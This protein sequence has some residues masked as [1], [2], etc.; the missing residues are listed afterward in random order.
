MKQL[1]A[2]LCFLL[3]S[4]TLSTPASAKEHPAPVDS[5][6]VTSPDNLIIPNQRIGAIRLGMGMDEVRRLLGKPSGGVLANAA[7]NQGAIWSYGDLNLQISFD[8]GAAPIVTSIQAHGWTHKHKTLDTLYW[9][10]IDPVKVAFQTSN[11]ITVGSSAF[12]VRRVYSNYGYE[13]S[14][15]GQGLI[16]YYKSIGLT[17]FVTADHIVYSIGIYTPQ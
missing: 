12:D 1:L 9:K 5:S 10:D 3:L 11:G 13:E 8:S 4:A 17:F 6:R 7:R 14:Q 15:P 2:I 16:M